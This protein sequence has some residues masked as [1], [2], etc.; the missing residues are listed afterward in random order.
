MLRQRFRACRRSAGSSPSLIR[1]L[2]PETAE[3]GWCV[4]AVDNSVVELGR[5]QEDILGL[6]SGMALQVLEPH[7]LFLGAFHS[8]EHIGIQAID[9]SGVAW[10][11]ALI[12]GRG[13]ESVDDLDLGH[14]VQHGRY[15][16][17]PLERSFRS[18]EIGPVV[19]VH[20]DTAMLGRFPEAF[21]NLV[22]CSAHMEKAS[23][24]AQTRWIRHPRE[25]SLIKRGHVK[26]HGLGSHLDRGL[27][28]GRGGFAIAHVVGGDAVEAVS[29]ADQTRER[30]RGLRC[31][32]QERPKRPPVSETKMS[33]AMLELYGRTIGTYRGS[34]V[35]SEKTPDPVL[36]LL[37]KGSKGSFVPPLQDATT[38]PPRGGDCW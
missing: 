4:I 7:G 3:A 19:A 1:R 27:S 26:H 22:P 25:D 6:I 23:P 15:P 2:S 5:M 14:A 20:L 11:L 30:A 32:G 34:G 33:E 38:A 8:A 9:E 21:C 29:M 16:A 31:A 10:V 17:N 37:Y 18:M 28:C 12:F 36:R 13:K 35:L 24:S